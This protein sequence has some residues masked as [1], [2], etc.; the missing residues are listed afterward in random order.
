MVDEV[1]FKLAT[2]LVDF[3]HLRNI[4]NE[5]RFFLT[6]NQ[7]HISIYRQLLFY[8]FKPSNLSFFLATQGGFVVG[9]LGITHDKS[10]NCFL[11]TEVVREDFRGMGIGIQMLDFAKDRYSP[12]VAE[13]FKDNN[14]S[15]NLHLKAGFRVSGETLNLI[16]M[17][18]G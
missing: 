11:V 14:P 3:L 4:R 6:N 7:S 13:I 1:K 17:Q 12:L 5:A 9:Y 10:K 2:S 8:F 18:Y 16:K 15:I